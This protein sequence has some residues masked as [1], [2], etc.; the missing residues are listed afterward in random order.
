MT[1]LSRSLLLSAVLLTSCGGSSKSDKLSANEVDAL[2][3]APML[4]VQTALT[5]MFT[6]PILSSFGV[7]C[8][9]ITELE[10]GGYS[11][12]GGCTDEDGQ[13]WSG[14][15][16]W[17]GA[18]ITW[19]AFEMP[20]MSIDGTQRIVMNDMTSNLTVSFSDEVSSHTATYTSYTVAG[21]MEFYTASLSG[22]PWSLDF[23]GQISVDDLGD[24]ET[25]GSVQDDLTCE[26]EPTSGGFTLD[27]EFT[28]EATFDGGTDC[29][30]CI[31]WTAD[32]Q[33]GTKC[34]EYGDTGGGG[35]TGR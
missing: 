17:E 19:T 24:F 8:P 32:D 15:M 27:G 9:T 28:F 34:F 31:S 33:K 2:L 1:Y 26:E 20:G 18:D 22:E 6:M 25:T 21:F 7:E 5:A 29:D 13:E 3:R 4:P 16:L 30:G 12:E 14:S 10:S 35:D 11:V 23:S